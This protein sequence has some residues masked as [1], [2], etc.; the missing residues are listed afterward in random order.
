MEPPDRAALVAAQE[1]EFAV[2]AGDASSYPVHPEQPELYFCRDLAGYGWCFRK[3]GH[4]NVGFGRL[5]ARGA[6]R[7]RPPSSWSS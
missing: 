5:D 2:D 3:Q 7:A 4:L 1:V 6:A